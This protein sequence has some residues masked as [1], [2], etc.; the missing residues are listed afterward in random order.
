[1]ELLGESPAPTDYRARVSAARR[2]H[3]AVWDVL[4]SCRR[5]GSLDSSI[6]RQSESA[7]D[8]AGLLTEKPSIVA[9]ALNGGKAKEC[10]RRH[11]R[12]K[13]SPTMLFLPST[14]PANA[15]MSYSQKAAA[16][17]Q[18]LPFLRLN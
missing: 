14:S 1:M 9:V 4:S 15:R 11:S 5:E 2:A 17:R 12:P 18:I 3:V 10:F 6:C 16:W 13:H 8:I 7:N